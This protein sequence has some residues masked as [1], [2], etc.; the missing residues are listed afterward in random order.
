LSVCIK[1]RLLVRAYF[2][3]ETLKLI[4]SLKQPFSLEKP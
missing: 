2:R 3:L 1:L 4:S